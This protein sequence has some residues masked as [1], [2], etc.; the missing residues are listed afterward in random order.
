MKIKYGFKNI[1]WIILFDL[2]D[3]KIIK[4]SVVY[5]QLMA[6]D[7]STELA[8]DNEALQRLFYI[9]YEIK[10]FWPLFSYFC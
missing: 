1:L 7:S 6:F 10:Q 4:T 2:L 8:I 5:F 9:A 3:M